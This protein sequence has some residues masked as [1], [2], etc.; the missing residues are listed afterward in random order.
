MKYDSRD[1][2]T[3]EHRKVEKRPHAGKQIA[4]QS[5]DYSLEELDEFD[6]K[7]EGLEILLQNCSLYPTVNAWWSLG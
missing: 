5:E 2:S 1:F 7:T 6:W 4:S 3:L